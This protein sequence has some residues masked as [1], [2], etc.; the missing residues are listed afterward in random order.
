M[1]RALLRRTGM[2][3]AGAV[4]GVVLLEGVAAAHVTV[5]SP[6]MPAKGGD[7]EI[8]LRTPNEADTASL[9]K[10]KLD[11]PLGT[12][13]SNA[14]PLP[15]PGWTV[16]VTMTNLKTP[17]RMAH[18]TVTQAVASIVWT[19][20]PGQGTPASDFQSFSFWTEGL[21]DNTS[22]L[23]FAATQT[24]SDGSVVAWNQAT[25]PGGTMPDHPAPTLALAAADPAMP[26][27]TSGSTT[28][29]TARWLGAG[30][31]ALGVLG[32]GFGVV[33]GRRRSGA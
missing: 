12:P 9:V 19:A 23:V 33:R 31:L 24:Y 26:M 27:A 22:T 4:A 29:D 2:A 30:G 16:Q 11:L 20:Q 18:D 32:I 21:P 25:P 6:D 10:V 3:V 8:V 17:V 14:A 1:L 28:D 5:V 15:V 13:L 7:A